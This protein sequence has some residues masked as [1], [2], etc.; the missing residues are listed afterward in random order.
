M[1]TQRLLQLLNCI[2]WMTGSSISGTFSGSNLNPTVTIRGIKP[3]STQMT[4]NISYKQ[5]DLEFPFNPKANEAK[6][7]NRLLYQR[8]DAWL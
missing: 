5:Y 8:S 2:N 1:L 4:K 7:F 3:T 6:S